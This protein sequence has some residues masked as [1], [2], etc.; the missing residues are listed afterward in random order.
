MTNLQVAVLGVCALSLP[1]LVLV[2][3]C[4]IAF[5][6]LDYLEDVFSNSSMVVGNKDIF[7]H[8]GVLGKMMR[9]G[10]I[11]AMLAV[12]GFSV[13]KGLLDRGDVERLPGRLKKLLVA[14]LV[15]HLL[16]FILLAAV[17]LWIKLCRH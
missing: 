5:R 15:F 16:M 2:A 8:A 4:V 12:T 6:Y 17:G 3:W 11:S 1:F 13:R 10:S 7:S 14:L 9:V